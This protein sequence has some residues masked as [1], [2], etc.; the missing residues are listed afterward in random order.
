[1]LSSTLGSDS[2]DGGARS[3]KD[4]GPRLWEA[5]VFLPVEGVGT[6]SFSELVIQVCM[7][8]LSLSCLPQGRICI[9]WRDLPTNVVTL[10]LYMHTSLG[11]LHRYESQPLGQGAI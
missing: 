10:Y 1:M 8:P 7:R 2:L 11:A 4:L 6:V 5:V 9:T 3:P